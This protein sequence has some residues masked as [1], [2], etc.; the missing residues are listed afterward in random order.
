MSFAGSWYP[1]RAEACEAEIRRF[2]GEGEPNAGPAP[3]RC[4]GIVPHAGWFFSGAIACRVIR[5]LALAEPPEVLIIFGMHL[6]P[7][8]DCRIMA[9]GMWETP[10][11]TLAVDEG[12]AAALMERFEFVVETP[13][14]HVQDN[15]I[16]LQLPF[17]RYFM[18]HTR[19]LT[20]GVPPAA[21]AI[22]IGRAAVEAATRLGR[23]AKVLGSTD[24][25]HYGP[26]YGK[27]SHGSGPM[28]VQWVRQTNDRRM[29]ESML[30]LDAE[31]V[32]QEALAN[33]NA[34]CSGAVAAA[35]AAAKAMGAQRGEQLAYATSYERSPGESFV[36]YVGVVY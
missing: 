27:R 25:T 13:Q 33:E 17:V 19:I 29:V 32:I 7:A 26:N 23:R 2:I 36:G 3:V 5:Q 34:C 10:L 18:P 22:E 9:Q 21:V 11:G 35:L 16:E 4:A 31:G 1:E 30:A 15:T 8:S 24:L 12:L 14:R 20:M 28:A 6:H